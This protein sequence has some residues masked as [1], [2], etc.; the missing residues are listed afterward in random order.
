M[1]TIIYHITQKRFCYRFD[2]IAIHLKHNIL[3]LNEYLE[4]FRPKKVWTSS[5]KRRYLVQDK[6]PSVSSIGF[7]TT[8]WAVYVHYVVS[9]LAMGGPESRI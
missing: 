1:E 8:P 9:K 2:T 7:E 5:S 6:G 4:G 3:I